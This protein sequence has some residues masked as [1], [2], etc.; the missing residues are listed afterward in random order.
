M[1]V[2]PAAQ[3]MESDKTAL[4]QMW[5]EIGQ[6]LGREERR[7]GPGGRTLD[8]KTFLRRLNALAAESCLP[9][10]LAPPLSAKGRGAGWG[11]GVRCRRTR[12]GTS[13]PITFSSSVWANEA[14][15]A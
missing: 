8:R 7:H 5:G 11:P 13:K 2:T 10:S 3:E 1:G 15:R 6:W 12:R 14:S 4:E 9:R